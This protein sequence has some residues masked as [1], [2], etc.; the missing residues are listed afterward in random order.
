MQGD[1]R[2]TVGMILM[3]FADL[4]QKIE[5]VCREYHGLLYRKRSNSGLPRDQSCQERTLHIS[6]EL[7]GQ[8]PFLRPLAELKQLTHQFR[9]LL[10][11]YGT[12]HHPLHY[13]FVRDMSKEITGLRYLRT[14]AHPKPVP[15]P[16]PFQPAFENLPLLWRT[17]LNN[18]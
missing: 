4:P 9:Y 16:S 11:Q 14:A 18:R 13:P 12:S 8:V 15:R 5:I 10:K 6:S 7:S 17:L 2:P 3:M 1:Q